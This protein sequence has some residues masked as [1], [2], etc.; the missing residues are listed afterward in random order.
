MPTKKARR[1][2]VARELKHT[3][4]PL[5]I[6]GRIA[7]LI[8]ADNEYQTEAVLEAQGCTVVRRW[9]CCDLHTETVRAEWSYKGKHFF[10]EYG[11]LERCKPEPKPP[12]APIKRKRVAVPTAALVKLMS[13]TDAERLASNVKRAAEARALANALDAE[14]HLIRD[15][16][17]VMVN[18]G[19]PAYMAHGTWECKFSPT[20]T[21]VYDQ[22]NDPIHSFCIFCGAPEERK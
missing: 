10:T 7:R 1:R 2:S 4:L 21:C 11:R 13:S 22:S 18:P 9:A 14:S 20:G 12:Q 16:M 17:V 8:V 6:R 3:G 5:P 19:A 15:R